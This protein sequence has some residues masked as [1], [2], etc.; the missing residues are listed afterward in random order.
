MAGN[1]SGP[2][3]INDSNTEI[4]HL[5][6]MVR[7][8]VYPEYPIRSHAECFYNLR[9]SL[10]AHANSLHSVDIKGPDYRNH[11]F[12]VGFDTEKKLGLAFTGANTKNNLM[13]IKFT[14]HAGE[15]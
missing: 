5:H 10:G 9:Q 7:S 1:R 4:Q 12:V 2:T 6:L 11:K 15:N 8:K 3:V 13:T 14:N